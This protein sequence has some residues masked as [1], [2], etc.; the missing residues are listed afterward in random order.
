MKFKNFNGIDLV[1]GSFY[2]CKTPAFSESGY[3][4]AKAVSVVSCRKSELNETAYVNPKKEVV[5]E[6]TENEERLDSY[7]ILGIA[8]LPNPF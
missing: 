5:L 4:I 1:D 3:C 6:S 8:K 7:N 2:L